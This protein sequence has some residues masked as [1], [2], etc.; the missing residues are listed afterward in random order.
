MGRAIDMIER[1]YVP[2]STFE[3]RGDKE[4]ELDGYASVFNQE[5]VIAGLFREEV[6]PGAFTKTIGEQDIRALWNHDVNIVL[7]RNKAGTL[8]LS[9]DAT[10]LRSV[11]KPPD[12]EWGRPIVDAIKRG[13]V[14]QMSI[15]FRAIKQE[16]YYPDRNSQ[17]LPK[18]TIRE[19]RLYDVSPVTFPAFE[20]TSISARAAGIE[21][22]GDEDPFEIVRRL[23]R[24]AERGLVLTPEDRQLIATVFENL[25]SY[26]PVAEPSQSGHSAEDKGEPSQSGH[27]TANW[28][29]WFELATIS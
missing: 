6:A 4:P 16:W 20:Q 17:E 26:L 28:R 25:R 2:A 23:V 3:V 13:D 18:R 10:G 29:A 7:G 5:T 14:S 1:R 15:A 8:T 22:I 11:I 19:A 24:C 9:E 27:S 12:N 21:T